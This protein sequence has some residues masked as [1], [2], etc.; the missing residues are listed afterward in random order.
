MTGLERYW[1]RVSPAHLL[2]LPISWLFG[3]LAATR[4]LLYR[5]GILPSHRLSV[6][7]VVIGNISVGGTGKTPLTLAIA[8]HLVAMGWHPVIVSRGFGGAAKLQPVTANST[9]QQVGDE[10]LLMAQRR[11]CPVWTGTDRV[12]T[13]RAALLSHPECNVVLCDDGLQHYRLQRDFEIVVVD[14][15]RRFGNGLL[16][17]AGPLRE[18]EWRLNTVDAVVVNGGKPAADQYDMQLAGALLHNLRHPERTASAAELRGLHLHAVAGI[19]HPQRFFDHLADLGLTVTPHAFP[20]HHPYSASDLDFTDCDALLLTEKDAVK[21]APFADDRYWVLRVDTQ[22]D[23][24]LFAHLLRKIAPN[25][26]KTA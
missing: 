23:S 11:I 7:V 5:T 9:A 22:V 12:A 21:C 25:G 16:L 26:R 14:G 8:S 13:A 17:P 6:P 15:R 2:L 1:Y 24:A 4:R 19:G 20:D 18:G 3:A 10:P